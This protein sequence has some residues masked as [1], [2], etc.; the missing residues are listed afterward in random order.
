MGCN[1]HLDTIWRSSKT[2]QCLLPDYIDEWGA[3]QALIVF[4]RTFVIFLKSRNGCVLLGTM[5]LVRGRP[6]RRRGRG[7]TFQLNFNLRFCF[8]CC[9]CTPHV[10]A[11]LTCSDQLELACTTPVMGWGRDADVPCACTRHVGN[12]DFSVFLDRSVSFLPRHLL[13]SLS[14]GS[15][16]VQLVVQSIEDRFR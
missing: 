13:N 16:T 5:L 10:F 9:A 2:P 7:L 3:W 4:L 6:F 14:L 8:H 11:T 15:L 1:I 12:F